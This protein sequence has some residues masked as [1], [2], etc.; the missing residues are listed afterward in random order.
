MAVSKEQVWF[1][2]HEGHGVAIVRAES[3]EQATVAAAKFWGVPWGKVAAGIEVE[4]TKPLM[5]NICAK[6]GKM[7]QG[8][9][10]ILCTRCEKAQRDEDAEQVRIK[11]MIRERYKQEA[12]MMKKGAEDEDGRGAEM[13]A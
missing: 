1:L 4:R 2:R 6:C 13:E 7:F 8:G 11:R 9:R 12:R 3:F 5:T 10:E